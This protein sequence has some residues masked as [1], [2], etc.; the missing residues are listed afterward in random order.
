MGGLP[1]LSN[2][3]CHPGRAGG[4]PVWAKSEGHRGEEC[5]SAKGGAK[6][7]W[8]IASRKP[9][10]AER[11][12]APKALYQ[13]KMKPEPGKC[14]NLSRLTQ[15]GTDRGK[16]S[17]RISS[18]GADTSAS[19]RRRCAHEPGSMERRRLRCSSGGGGGT[20]TTASRNDAPRRTD[21]PRGGRGRL[22]HRI[23]AHAHHTRRCSK[24]CAMMFSTTDLPRLYCAAEA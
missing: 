6:V 2:C 1:E 21:V 23:L 22:A 5:G 13:F 16:T 14:T 3:Y 15:P 11:R 9:M 4:L 8:V 7:S 19:A 10:G 24:P 18:A 17:P 12:I 20:A